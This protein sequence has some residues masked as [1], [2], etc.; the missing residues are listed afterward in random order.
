MAL[1]Q[2]IF[3]DS[4][5]HL[6]FKAF[7]SKREKVIQEAR[8]KGVKFILVPGANIKTSQ[9]AIQIARE[10][11]DIFAAIGLH[12]HHAFEIKKEEIPL[13]ISQ[14]EKMIQSN[15]VVAV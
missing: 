14:L 6:N 8:D 15:K 1:Q 5:C 3:F 13:I 4:H 12:P 9:K 2:N 10:H 11:R 7:S